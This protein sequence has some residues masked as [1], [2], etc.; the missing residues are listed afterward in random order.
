MPAVALIEPT[1]AV[2]RLEAIYGAGQT[3]GRFTPLE[4][5]I[6]CIL[7]QHTT[8]ASSFP[9]FARLME[10]LKMWEAIA[11][12]PPE[13]V[14]ALIRPA[15]LSKSKTKYIQSCLRTLFERTGAYALDHLETMSTQE[16]RRW[17]ESLPGVGPKTA[18]I[19]LCFAMDRD[20]CPIDTHVFRVSWRVGWIER[21]VGEAAAHDRIAALLPPGLAYRFHAALVSHGRA[22]CRAQKPQCAACPLADGCRWRANEVAS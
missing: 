13:V 5:L 15:G 19:T 22:L 10:S 7:S 3:R 12:A 18:A 4:E 8:D 9:A 21:S 16:A 14:E 20:F 17:L 11:S 1:V 6:A 2:E